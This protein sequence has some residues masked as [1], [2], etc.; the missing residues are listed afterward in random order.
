MNPETVKA[1]LCHPVFETIYPNIDLEWY[2]EQF[3]PIIAQVCTTH[4]LPSS[5]VVYTVN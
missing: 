3:Y 5:L 2:L 4:S 1:N